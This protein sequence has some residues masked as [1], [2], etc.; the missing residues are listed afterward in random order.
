MTGTCCT[1]GRGPHS[2]A[3]RLSAVIASTL[4]AG[5]LLLLPKCPLCLAMWLALAMGVSFPAAG[6]AWMRGGII[7]LWVGAIGILIRRRRN[8]PIDKVRTK[9]D[10][11]RIGGIRA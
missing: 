3:R 8:T 5:L 11:I 6:I 9:S 2:L 7:L 1:S 10:T 4:P